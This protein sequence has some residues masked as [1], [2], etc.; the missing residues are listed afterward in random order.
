MH[1]DRRIAILG[2]LGTAALAIAMMAASLL[3]TDL[4]RWILGV[5]FGPTWTAGRDFAIENG[6]N[7]GG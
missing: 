6:R 4:P 1:I 7:A 2:L 3:F 5:L